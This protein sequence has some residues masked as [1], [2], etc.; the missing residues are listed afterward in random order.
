MNNFLRSKEEVLFFK[1]TKVIVLRISVQF[2][3]SE[4][5]I[6]YHCFLEPLV[7][8]KIITTP[9]ITVMI[10]LRLEVM[11]IPNLL[12]VMMVKRWFGECLQGLWVLRRIYS[13]SV[14]MEKCFIMDISQ[15]DVGSSAEI[16]AFQQC[17]PSIV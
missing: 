5:T 13:T 11:L 10:L 17:A 14:R 3:L 4:K 6:N 2:N 9:K 12:K 7:L 8:L 1:S 16:I 15:Q